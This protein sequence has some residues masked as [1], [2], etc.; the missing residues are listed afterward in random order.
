MRKRPPVKKGTIPRLLKLIREFYPVLLP[1]ALLCILISAAIGAMP[2]L[3]MQRVISVIEENLHIGSWDAAAPKIFSAVALLVIFYLLSLTAG[4]IYHQ[5]L[6]II[7]QG[8]LKKLR[9]KMFR[10]MQKLP[11]KYFDANSDGDIMSRYTND[12]D[13]LRQMISQTFPQLLISCVS[14]IT[15]FCIMLYFCVWLCIV[16]VAGVILMSFVTAKLG[17]NAAKHS[18]RQQK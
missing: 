6:A 17:G 13:A 8:T 16:V 9:C 3:F 15:I 4:I 18:M 7:T 2:A 1:I 10:I 14:V 12:I 5:L 11:I